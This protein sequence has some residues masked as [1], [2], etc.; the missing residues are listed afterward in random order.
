MGKEAPNDL[1]DIN[2]RRKSAQI[3][4]LLRF[5]NAWNARHNHNDQ[6]NEFNR[7]TFSDK[8]SSRS[9]YM[10]FMLMHG[11]TF[12][13]NCSMPISEVAADHSQHRR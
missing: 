10:E 8:T 9:V 3:R 1:I 12:I 6:F 13:G 4:R 2:P 5:A 7:E 11:K